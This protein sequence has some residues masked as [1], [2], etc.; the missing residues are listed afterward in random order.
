MVEELEMLMIWHS[1][2]AVQGL[3]SVKKKIAMRINFEALQR[4]LLCRFVISGRC[5][6]LY[7]AFLVQLVADLAQDSWW[8]EVKMVG[9]ASACTTLRQSG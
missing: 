7:L 1:V 6:P 8:Q 9:H 3:A 4:T 2:L 5:K